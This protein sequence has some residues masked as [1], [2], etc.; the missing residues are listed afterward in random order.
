MTT[1]R[2][3]A[4]SY[5]NAGMQSGRETR[6]NTRAQFV[7]PA[8]KV[9][10]DSLKGLKIAPNTPSKQPQPK[11]E[12]KTITVDEALSQKNIQTMNV[13]EL[14][15]L[16]QNKM[17]TASEKEDIEKRKEDL[18]LN[19]NPTGKTPEAAKL[20][21]DRDPDEE[22]ADDDKFDI[23]QGDFIDFLMKEVVLASAAWVGKKV[24]GQ[25]N[26]A[27]YKAS[28][29][30]WHATTD[31]LEEGWEGTKEFSKKAWQNLKNFEENL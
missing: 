19:T 1:A 18:G 3:S 2:Q 10:S 30:V 21:T 7:R 24:A 29:T 4:Q 9:N 22:I 31:V 11:Q 28:S 23:Q 26:V 27:L 5:A 13:D 8:P 20:K 6:N 14:S 12:T 16:N 17:L 25:V 15:D